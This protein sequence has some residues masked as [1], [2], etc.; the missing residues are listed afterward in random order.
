M[1]L[2]TKM[3]GTEDEENGFDDEKDFEDDDL[4]DEEEEDEE[5]DDEDLDEEPSA[6]KLKRTRKKKRKTKTGTKTRTGT[7]TKTKIG[8]KMKTKIGKKKKIRRGRRRE[9][10]K[11]A[12]RSARTLTAIFDGT[13][14]LPRFITGGAGTKPAIA[15]GGHG[16]LAHPLFVSSPEENDARADKQPIAL[17]AVNALVFE[18]APVRCAGPWSWPGAGGSCNRWRWPGLR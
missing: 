10:E 2:T 8:K 5:D 1:R 3:K 16:R 7:K 15:T 12:G 13:T 17:F 6:R 4:D 11:V 18:R 14:V 9:R